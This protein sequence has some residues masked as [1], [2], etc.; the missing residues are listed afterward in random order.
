M[1]EEYHL[2]FIKFEETNC[3]KD[4]FENVNIMHSNKICVTFLKGKTSNLK[5]NIHCFGIINAFSRNKLYVFKNNYFIVEVRFLNLRK[6]YIF[7]LK[8]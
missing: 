7:R 8:E 1:N 6:P 4:K 2:L 5:K 3:I